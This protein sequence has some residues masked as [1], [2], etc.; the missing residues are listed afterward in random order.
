MTAAALIL[1][2]ALGAAGGAL[3]LWVTALRA[4]LACSGR[5]ARA[6]ALL[7]LA[8]AGPAL[9]VLASAALARP[10]AFSVLPGVALVR[11]LWLSRARRAA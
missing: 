11:A 10:A 9:A 6:L 8:F 5:H 7:P 2:L 4:R 3:H 1:G